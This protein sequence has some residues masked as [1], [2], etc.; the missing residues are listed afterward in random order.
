MIYLF[1]LQELSAKGRA[2]QAKNIY[3]HL[4]GSRGYAGQKFKTKFKGALQSIADEQ[5][6]SG[7]P[8]SQGSTTA[9]SEE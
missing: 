7:D 3:P 1:K 4:L 5:G 9:M 6:S 8:S 2:N